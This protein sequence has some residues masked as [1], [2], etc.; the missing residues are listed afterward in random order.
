MY[1]N[2]TCLI[3]GGT[4]SWGH[5]LTRKLLQQGGL[6]KEIRIFSRNEFSQVQMQRE[7]A[8]DA[9]LRFVIGDVRDLDATRAVCQDVDYVF[10]LAA[11]KHVPV[12]EQQPSEALLTNVIGTKNVIQSSIEC[13]VKKVIDVSTDK[14]VDAA[15]FYGITKAM[16]EKLILH[17]NGQSKKTRFVCIRGGNVLGT[18]GSVVPLFKAQATLHGELTLTD[19]R[20][21]RFFL[22]VSEA[23]DLLLVAAE[24]AIGGETFVMKMKSCNIR[25]LAEVLAD[26]VTGTTVPI[27]E[28]GMRSGEKL[29]EVLVS[30]QEATNTFEYGS[31]Y[32]VIL[33]AHGSEALRTKYGICPRVSFIEYDSNL[34]LLPKS[35]IKQMLQQG[36]FLS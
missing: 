28:I 26:S 10:H 3:T 29:H 32:Y 6:P 34:D 24:A 15:N 36:G 20:M 1:D 23:I 17:A 2:Q 21:T 8:A 22:T 9:P 13:G 16:G 33:Q 4:G 25:D 27:R 30:R 11:L 19:S 12:C 35:G 7:F 5:E 18:N 31:E 14:A